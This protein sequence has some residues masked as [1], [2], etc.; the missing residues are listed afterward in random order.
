[1]DGKY[2]G[3]RLKDELYEAFGVPKGDALYL[4]DLWVL[5]LDNIDVDI[6]EWYID[7]FATGD[8]ADW[9]D[10]NEVTQGTVFE[11]KFLT[12]YRWVPHIAGRGKESEPADAMIAK[13][14]LVEGIRVI[15]R[16]VPIRTMQNTETSMLLRQMLSGM[17]TTSNE[18][19]SE[20]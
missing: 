2:S 4:N 3:W 5:G 8:A 18:V 17:R 14:I 7:C 19:M 6:N 12:K 15:E 9:I 10:N 1:M 20:S 13:L 11:G 16:D